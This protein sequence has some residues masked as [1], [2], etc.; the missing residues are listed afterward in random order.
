MK[1]SKLDQWFSIPA[2]AVGMA[3]FCNVVWGTAFPFIKMGYR[4]FAIDS[5]DTASIMCFAGVRFMIG[6]LLVFIFGSLLQGKILPMPKGKLFL[7]SAGLGLWQTTLQYA[8]YYSAVALLTGSMGGIL[9]STQS[10]MGVILAHFIYGAADRINAPK[11]LGCILGFGGV[12][13]VT[14]GNHGSGS[15]LGIFSMLAASAVMAASG[16]MNKALGK[17]AN[18][19]SVCVINLGIGGLAMLLIGLALGGSLSPQSPAALP[20]LIYLAFV[21]GAGYLLWQLLMK[22][23][24]VSQISMF[25]LIIP[26]VNVLLSALLNGEPLFEWNY[27]VALALV[28]VGIW[29][30]NRPAPVKEKE[31]C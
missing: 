29:L 4:L 18:S 1:S 19:F 31:A 11:A 3:I 7:A 24:P 22:N 6:G 13:V 12:L 2:V 27:L 25:G 26:I 17:V 8:F 16:P 10:F 23:N 9:N 20:V 14:L 30:V 5:A 28:G 15:P 21:S